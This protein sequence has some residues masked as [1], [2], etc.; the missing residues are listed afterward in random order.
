MKDFVYVD[1]D[2]RNLKRDTRLQDQNKQAI[3]QT[4]RTDE[5]LKKQ[6]KDLND[7]SNED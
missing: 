4:S 5:T 6:L 2:R 3:D 1:D 7:F